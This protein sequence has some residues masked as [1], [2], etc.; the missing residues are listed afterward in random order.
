MVLHVLADCFSDCF[1]DRQ[2][3]TGTRSIK[4]NA[5]KNE[6]NDELDGFDKES[7]V[8]KV[9]DELSDVEFKNLYELVSS[10]FRM[11]H[12]SQ[13]A[14]EL[15]KECVGMVYDNDSWSRDVIKEYVMNQMKDIYR[16][17]KRDFLK[18]HLSPEEYLRCVKNSNFSDKVESVLKRLFTIPTESKTSTVSKSVI[19]SESKNETAVPQNIVKAPVSK[20]AEKKANLSE[21]QKNIEI[22]PIEN[23]A[24]PSELAIIENPSRWT[25]RADKWSFVRLFVTSYEI[26]NHDYDLRACLQLAR[27]RMSRA[28]VNR[29]QNEYWNKY[30]ET[31]PELHK[32]RKAYM[33]QWAKEHPKEMLQNNRRCAENRKFKMVEA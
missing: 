25:N 33:R 7:R 9:D 29:K 6:L 18:K 32:K 8:L 12:C 27:R 28:E 16:S 19:S 31:H 15:F 30:M 10:K 22:K 26:E 21:N 11:K 24:I 1:F 14:K 20:P 3:Q 4:M 23:K 17:V 2:S 13:E 5:K